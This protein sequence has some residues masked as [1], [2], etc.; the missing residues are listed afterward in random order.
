MFP[1]PRPDDVT[2]RACCLFITVEPLKSPP[3]KDKI[4]TLS[5]QEPY[6]VA[7]F[8]LWLCVRIAADALRQYNEN[9]Y[10]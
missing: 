9:Y 3:F 5:S 8:S 2:Y 7:L 6:T 10:H 4:A 1:P